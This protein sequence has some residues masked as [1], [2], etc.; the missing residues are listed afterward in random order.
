MVFFFTYMDKDKMYMDKATLFMD[1]VNMFMDKDTLFM[2]KD[3]MFM[4]NLEL[5]VKIKRNSMIYRFC[6]LEKVLS[7][8]AGVCD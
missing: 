8:M 5:I 1:K 4:H 7:F 2:D 3:K 6:Q